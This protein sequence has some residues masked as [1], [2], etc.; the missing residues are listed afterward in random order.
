MFVANGCSETREPNYVFDITEIVS[1]AHSRN[2]RSISGIPR[3]LLLLAYHAHRLRP[4]TIKI[5]YFDVINQRYVLLEEVSLLLKFD[6]LKNEIKS[7]VGF[8]KNTNKSKHNRGSIKH[9]FHAS[10]RYVEIEIKKFL[11]KCA[12]LKQSCVSTLSLDKCDYLICLGGMWNLL[13]LFMFIRGNKEHS[14]RLVTLIHDMIPIKMDVKGVVPRSQF[15]NS[16]EETLKLDPK[17]LV[18]SNSTMIDVQEWC[19]DTGRNGLE[20]KKFSLADELIPING[21]DV[22]RDVLALDGLPYVLMVGPLTGRKNAERL[23]QAWKHVTAT[24]SIDDMPILVFAGGEDP[25]TLEEFRALGFDFIPKKTKFIKKP[26]DYELKHLYQNCMFS[27]YP[28]LYEGWGLPIGE[29]LWHGKICA[30]SD[31]SSMPEAGGRSCEYFDPENVDNIVSVL[32]RLISDAV[33]LQSRNSSID[34]SQLKTWRDASQSLLDTLD[35]FYVS[36]EVA[37]ACDRC[38]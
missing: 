25:N 1:F 30:T 7:K 27:V 6:E 2:E 37:L 21:Y 4:E 17:L 18:Y 36:D 5:G 9:V 22:R 11:Q 38:I 31:R 10:K 14:V 20:I 3:V 16:I 19:H 33:Y 34:H 29:S 12:W 24:L 8:A 13:D 32:K 23:I 15:K 35:A 28:S 26:N